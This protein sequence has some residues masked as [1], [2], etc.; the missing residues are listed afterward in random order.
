MKILIMGLPG[1]GKTWLGSKLGQRFGIPYWDADDIRRIYSDWDFTPQ[2]RERQALRMRKLAEV[3]PI[4]ISGF[5]C[6]LP[7]YRR[8]FFPDKLI[9]MDTVQESEYKDTNKI[10]TPP[11]KYDLRITKWIDENQLYSC[12]ED[13]NLGT[14]DTQNF[15]NE[16]MQRL[17]KLS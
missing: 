5:V 8:H 2:G 4:S 1:S 15:L 16:L 12:L 9:W 6:P 17:A 11:A 14:M 10:F 3:N 7:G 13:F